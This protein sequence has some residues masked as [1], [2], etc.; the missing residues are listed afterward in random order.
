M[1]QLAV[2]HEAKIATLGEEGEG[3][4]APSGVHTPPLAEGN[5]AKLRDTPGVTVDADGW[6][7]VTPQASAKRKHKRDKHKQKRDETAPAQ[8]LVDVQLSTPS[9]VAPHGS[10]PAVGPPQPPQLGDESAV[11]GGA[12]GASAA[13]AHER[14]GTLVTASAVPSS[15]VA[16]LATKVASA[17]DTAGGAAAASDPSVA[18]ARELP[19]AGV[20]PSRRSIKRA[21][22]EA[23]AAAA[24]IGS[25]AAGLA[26]G[27]APDGQGLRPPAAHTPSAAARVSS[28]VPTASAH[29]RAVAKAS[30]DIVPFSGIEPPLAAASSDVGNAAATPGPLPAAPSSQLP[31]KAGDGNKSATKPAAK[32]S[33]KASAPLE[34][35][36]SATLACTTR[37]VATPQP[38]P[39]ALVP[40]ERQAAPPAATAAAVPAAATLANARGAPD[41]AAP[42]AAASAQAPHA[43]Q[44]VEPVAAAAAH[45]ARGAAAVPTSTALTTDGARAPA[46]AK[47]KRKRKSAAPAAA[48]A[49]APQRPERAP[50]R[51][52]LADAHAGGQPKHKRAALAPP[53][54]HA[55]TEGAP[56]AVTALRAAQAG[57]SSARLPDPLAGVTGKHN[58]R[59]GGIVAA[60]APGA[61]RGTTTPGPRPSALSPFEAAVLSRFAHF[62]AGILGKLD[63]LEQAIL[64]LAAAPARAVGAPLHAGASA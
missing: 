17:L 26:A 57:G 5:E 10:A 1:E 13:P 44:P 46:P 48:P 28:P 12:L 2:P 53:E 39:A 60:T 52:A 47:R 19:E 64:Q 25:A 51:S 20:A 37:A 24:V 15:T 42:P 29:K 58:A 62:E 27:A 21:R 55:R 43:P 33:A 11:V 3:I 63:R 31:R 23:N 7:T 32:A 14:A 56:R 30:Q 34:P 9:A 54:A 22:K 45:A 50:K 18:P 35:F 36:G 16:A 4:R 40:T 6:I 38:V 61:G 59:P 41:A 8:S 49:D